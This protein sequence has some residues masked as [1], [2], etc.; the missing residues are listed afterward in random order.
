MERDAVG[1]PYRIA[2]KLVKFASQEAYERG[3]PDE[4]IETCEWYEADGTLVTDPARL[5]QLEASLG[6]EG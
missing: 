1:L 5:A 2:T 4:V 3:E 6:Q